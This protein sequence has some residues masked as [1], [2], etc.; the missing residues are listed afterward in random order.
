[1]EKL[2]ERHDAYI[3][4]ISINNAT[5]HVPASAIEAFRTTAPWSEFGK[6]VE[7]TGR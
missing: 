7:M 4:A 6:F 1:M 2:F 5:L 3:S